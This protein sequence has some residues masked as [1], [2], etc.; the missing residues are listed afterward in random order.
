M[1]I[2]GDALIMEIDRV[3][4]QRVLYKIL[5]CKKTSPDINWLAPQ[6]VLETTEITT[7]T[8]KTQN[9]ETA[10]GKNGSDRSECVYIEKCHSTAADNF[11]G[12]IMDTFGDVYPW[13]FFD[14]GYE[15]ADAARFY[16]SENTGALS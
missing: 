12:F 6:G 10:S 15:L 8:R 4:P 1:D 2:R 5:I 14:H 11:D 13:R 7:A 16:T 3:A 9:T